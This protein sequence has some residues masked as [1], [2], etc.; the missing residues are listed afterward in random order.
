M[1]NGNPK[2]VFLKDCMGDA[3]LQLMKTEPFEKITIK[4]IVTKADVGRSTYFR[5]FHSK[6]ELLSWKMLQE[7][8]RFLKERN[9]G[10]KELREPTRDVVLAA[11]QFAYKIREYT[12][13]IRHST[14]SDVILEMTFKRLKEVIPENQSL[15]DE[16]MSS[17]IIYGASG[18]ARIWSSRG[19]KE[20]PEEMTDMVVDQYKKMIQKG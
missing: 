3:L 16:Y 4:E 19:Y 15:E 5:Y 10:D 14:V 7:F 12:S 13:L 8:G 17:F 6:E 18:I 9:I 11:F 20:T 2:T 1:D